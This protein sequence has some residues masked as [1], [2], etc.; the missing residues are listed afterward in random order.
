MSEF[1]PGSEWSESLRFLHNLAL[2][3]PPFRHNM[4]HELRANDIKLVNESHAKLHKA[5]HISVI[6]ADDDLADEPAHESTSQALWNLLFAFQNLI[7]C[8]FRE[9]KHFTASQCITHRLEL[10]NAGNIRALYNHTYSESHT[11]PHSERRTENI[12]VFTPDEND[13]EPFFDIPASAKRQAQTLIDDDAYQQASSRILRDAPVAELNEQNLE[14]IK[15]LFPDKLPPHCL[16]S[17]A[18][19]SRR[20]RSQTATPT[21]HESF[22]SL[23]ESTTLAALR[24][25]RKRT[26]AGPFADYTDYLRHFALQQTNDETGQSN[27]RPYFSLFLKTMQ[28]LA[29][30]NLPPKIARTFRAT[31]FVALH[32]D[33]T[34]LSKLRPIGVGTAYRRLMGSIIM[35]HMS[36]DFASY[37][38]P[39][40]Q[41]GVGIRGGLDTLVHLTQVMLDKYITS[42]QK[43]GKSPTHAL[44]LLDITN[45]F[46]A[47]SR[48]SA[49]ATLLKHPA[50]RKLVPFFDLLYSEPN[51]C[52]YRRPNGTWTFFLQHEGYAQG[53]PLSP[54]FASL[55]LHEV[56]V[57]I[58]KELAER[59]T[60]RGDNDDISFIAAYFDDCQSFLKYIDLLWF[61]LRFIQLGAPHG[62]I[63]NF[64]KT[65]IFTS[66][67]GHSPLTSLPHAD[68]E[69]LRKVLELLSPKP[70]S[71][72]EITTGVRTLGQPVGSPE[73][74]QSFLHDALA[75]FENNTHRINEGFP[76][77]QSRFL[78]FKFCIRPS[79][80]HLMGSDFLNNAQINL[81]SDATRFESEFTKRIDA[82]TQAFIKRLTSYVPPSPQSPDDTPTPHILP[83]HSTS[84]LYL[85][86]SKGGVGY[87]SPYVSATSSFVIPIARSIRLAEQGVTCPITNTT[88]HLPKPMKAILSPW[89]SS[90]IRIF[91]LFRF[92]GKRVLS[93]HVANSSGPQTN[94]DLSLLTSTLQLDGLRRDLYRKHYKQEASSLENNPNT[95][96]NFQS[97]TSTLTSIP[98]GSMSR[99]NKD[100]RIPSDLFRIAI[101]R[102]L[103]L[104]VLPPE[105][106]GAKCNK[107]NT[108]LDPHGDHFFTCRHHKS[109]ISNTI[110]DSLTH[111]CRILG[112][113]SGFTNSSQ[114]VTRETSQLLPNALSRRP[115]DVGMHLQPT[116]LPRQ[117]SHAPSFLAIDV[118][119]PSPPSSSRDAPLSSAVTVI[120]QHREKEK[121]KFRVRS[122]NDRNNVLNDLVNQN[123]LFIPFSVDH[124]GGLGPLAHRLLFGPNDTKAPPWSY[125]TSSNPDLRSIRLKNRAYGEHAA[126]SLL[127]RADAAWEAN[128]PN[129]RYGRSYHTQTPSQWATQ[130]LG[131]NITFALSENIL[132]LL[133][134]HQHPSNIDNKKDSSRGRHLFVPAR[135]RA[136][137]RAHRSE[138]CR[139]R[140]S[141]QSR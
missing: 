31:Y 141:G 45:M 86:A 27:S 120:T 74:I 13:D 93:F 50:F 3:P 101:Q 81:P 124:L 122:S 49:R 40:G 137:I 83:P 114:S 99:Q 76:D 110:R 20:T 35:R 39:Q 11:S 118:T 46:N 96:A 53:C 100:H 25:V 9:N 111:V 125:V 126:L 24:K 5:L 133:R 69:I 112:P 117:S 7:F 140:S 18:A 16:P 139:R 58:N 14:I 72:P 65:K 10:F 106:I 47:V 28:I 77:L 19:P 98:I 116:Y 121:E 97:L 138:S 130:F 127:P 21:S 22:L 52:W 115:A 23:K 8:P 108:T 37:L 107:C 135:Y 33:K 85:P 136:S 4:F 80:D 95:E 79:I 89:E 55:V 67:T 91:K 92:Y 62:I 34:D 129:K 73:F 60:E 134:K 15:K 29:S 43:Q 61:I 12:E 6:P 90:N 56:L 119:V 59:A 105:L 132:K 66:V 1:F 57:I 41:L 30:G 131:L 123:I 103:R 87:R 104:P 36:H 2:E 84:L 44:L 63:I 71:K 128:N 78:I 109:A 17:A 70:T 42:L 102:K 51:R 68:A 88:F 32:K 38:T 113:L 54:V 94:T 75:K 64:D 48:E 82:L 26:A